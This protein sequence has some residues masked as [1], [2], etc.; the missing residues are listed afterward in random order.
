MS[1]FLKCDCLKWAKNSRFSRL[2]NLGKK[3]LYLCTYI[4]GLHTANTDL[5]Y[6]VQ[7]VCFGPGTN[8]L[9]CVPGAKRFAKT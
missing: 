5:Q 7:Y 8:F 6:A 2:L 1:V 4:E 9:N 3:K